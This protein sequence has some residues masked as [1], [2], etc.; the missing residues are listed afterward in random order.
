MN[1]MDFVMPVVWIT[2]GVIFD[3]F[4]TTKFKWATT[5]GRRKIKE[6]F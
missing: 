3:E 2:V 6:L 1:L 4:F 5:E